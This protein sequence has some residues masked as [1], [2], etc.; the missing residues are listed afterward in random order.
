[1]SAYIAQ[2]QSNIKA[3]VDVVLGPKTLIVGKNGS[4]KTSIINAV[5]MGLTQTVSDLRGR[6]VAK[7]GKDLI[8][9][10]RK[11]ED[12][13]MCAVTLS[14]NKTTTVTIE[15]TATGGGRAKVKGKVDGAMPFLEVRDIL[16]SK[17][18]N[19]RKWIVERA[20]TSLSRSDVI[21]L[22]E[23]DEH[24]ARYLLLAGSS[25]ADE[26]S[27]LKNVEEKNN[28]KI[29]SYREERKANE[30][31]LEKL[32]ASLPPLP[33]EQEIRNMEIQVD[34]I[35]KSMRVAADKKNDQLH[36]VESLNK[37]R[38]ELSK[39][40]SAL[41]VS[42]KGYEVAV[43]ASNL[44]RPVSEQDELVVELRKRI[45]DISK[46]HLGLGMHD[47][48][49]CLKGSA[50]D[51]GSR[52][53]DLDGMNHSIEEALQ[54]HNQRIALERTIGE[55]RLSAG[56][57][58]KVIQDSEAKIDEQGGKIEESI[59]EAL[60]NSWSLSQAKL[61]KLKSTQ[62][63]WSSMK[64]MKD[65]IEAFEKR[66]EEGKAFAV[67]LKK[68]LETVAEGSQGTFTKT[69][70]SFLPKKYTFGLEVGDDVKIGFVS[71]GEINE[72][73]SGAEWATMIMAMSAACS[74][75]TQLNVI[76]PEERAFD[77]ETL[78]NVME[79]LSRCPYQVILTSTIAPTKELDGWTIVNL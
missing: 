78:Y 52:V 27:I 7:R 25:K 35:Y 63:Q 29:K 46:I 36:L 44:S 11:S 18:E 5:E 68:V 40:V 3:G 43:T 21:G 50:I 23:K 15:R 37:A 72:A 34:N 38:A 60:K 48:M 41:V 33:T 64:A 76:T 39:I 59:V 51:F 24:R 66:I 62:D 55:L 9:L 70:Q 20:S 79:S 71:D 1:M 6:K 61:H 67:A 54:A 28:D 30:S 4:G 8:T 31:V 17:P 77:P 47:C 16:T 42:E 56:I 19:L 14:T 13:L 73:L 57:H 58:V 12:S 69:V 26:V 2:V 65:Q 45:M 22:L 32:S 75:S 10:V 49:V 53:Q 74:D